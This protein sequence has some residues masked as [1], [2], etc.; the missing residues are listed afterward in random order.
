MNDGFRFGD[1]SEPLPIP[2]LENGFLLAAGADLP[3]ETAREL[4]ELMSGLRCRIDATILSEIGSPMNDTSVTVWAHP[5][6]RREAI[7]RWVQVLSGD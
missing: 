2:S 4:S 1:E 7:A 5:D 3:W 6:D